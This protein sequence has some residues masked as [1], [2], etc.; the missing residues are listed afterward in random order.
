MRKLKLLHQTQSSKGNFLGKRKRPPK[1][2]FSRN[3]TK[4]MLSLFSLGF[5][6]FLSANLSAAVLLV[7]GLGPPGP[8]ERAAA[9]TK[10]PPDDCTAAIP[11]CRNEENS[12]TKAGGCIENVL[13]LVML[14][15]AQTGLLAPP[16]IPPAEQ[17]QQPPLSQRISQLTILLLPQELTHLLPSTVPEI[18]GYSHRVASVI[19][20]G[21]PVTFSL[22]HRG[23]FWKG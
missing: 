10:R 19:A 2:S 4:K 16:P 5:T 14:L 22:Q 23:K 15:Q 8:L 21:H 11:C 6:C 9:M 17:Q 20:R 12:P 7:P 18:T 3:Q 1:Q 13:V